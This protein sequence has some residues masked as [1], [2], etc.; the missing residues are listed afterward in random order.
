MSK[1]L[2]QNCILFFK[3]FALIFIFYQVCRI[4][5][6]FYNSH[7]LDPWDWK[8]FIGGLRFDLAALGFL[9][10]AFA[11]LHIF[12][13]KFQTRAGYQ[14]FLFYSFYLVNI[15]FLCLNYVDYEYFKFIGRRSSY[16][17]ITA[18]GMEQEIPGLLKNFIVDY[19]WIP[20]FMFLSFFIFWLIYRKIDYKIKR[21]YINVKDI[22][23]A[24]LVIGIMLVLG[25]GGLQHK[26]I[27][28]VDAS[29]YGG[30]KNTAL[31]LNTPFSVIKTMGKS[32]VL[33]EV[34]FFTDSELNKVF[35]P[36]Q[37]FKYDSINKKNVVLLIVESFGRE[38][39][40]RGL[41]P[42]MDSLA[43]N[44]HFFENAFANGKVSI[45]A[46]PS[47]ISS[48][49]SLM[50]RTFISSSYALNDVYTL[51]KI[52]KENGYHTAFFHGAFNGSQNFDQYANV[53]GFDEYYGKNEYQGPEAF[54]GAW[55]IFD[56][57]F[58]QFYAKK[59][60]EFK[61][62]F[63]TTLFTIS[64][65]NPYTIPE[66][67][68]GKFPKGNADIH[69]SIAYADYSLKKF[70]ET[71]KTKEW[72]N[73]TIFVITA[74]HTCSEPKED[75]WKTN[76]GKFRVPILFFAP[77]DE[78]LSIEKVEK[79]FQQIDILPS[80]MDYLQINTKIVTYGKS[81]K[82]EQDFVV[83]Y[84]DNIYNYEKGDYYLA[85]DGKKTLGL[86]NWKTDP[87]L[88]N[89][90]MNTELEVLKQMEDFIKAYI[91]SFNFRVKNNQLTID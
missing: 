4:G 26:P 79:N 59:L 50:N 36:I 10:M 34:Q 85:F 39:M 60:D 24:I 23:I 83:N 30:L 69:E 11:L 27:R 7:L 61:K 40:H 43:Q 72:Y 53:A 49:P 19:W 14:Q 3:R 42:F 74:D 63:F 41:T 18:T 31:V 62:P 32:E 17:F 48:I 15:F 8:V 84:L 38:T 12:P 51:P 6:Y 78:S 76:V 45:D 22:I 46:V 28:L 70:F 25:R 67:Y 37:E 29:Q 82:S 5:F 57:E 88:K 13:G 35:N 2:S 1:L 73:N 80:L 58:L 20:L 81:Y 54:D 77:G 9:N 16:A 86:Y 55:G 56:E 71:A 91:Q 90:L 87:L 44:S 21:S 66:K 47:A 52:L 33:E 75:H 68:K 65:H 64:S 89:N